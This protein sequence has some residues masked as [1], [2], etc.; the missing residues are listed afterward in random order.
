MTEILRRLGG[1]PDRSGLEQAVF[2]VRN[3][4]LGIG[5]SVSFGPDRRQGMQRVY[6]TV[7][8]GDHFALL[9]NWEAKFGAS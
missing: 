2:T 8:D 4:P 1:R 5:E 3:F 7:A 6:Y 9:D